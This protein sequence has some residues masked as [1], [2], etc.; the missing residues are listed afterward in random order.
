MRIERH[1]DAAGVLVLI[2]DLLPSLATIRCAENAALSV[3]PIG[4]AECRDESDVRICWI[5]N[6]FADGTRIVQSD[7]FQVL[8]PSSVL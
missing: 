7:I 5:N 6:D 8:P 4:M 3:G 1:I 2:K